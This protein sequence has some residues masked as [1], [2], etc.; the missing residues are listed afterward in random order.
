MAAEAGKAP[1]PGLLG[2]TG[3]GRSGRGEVPNAQRSGSVFGG[4]GGILLCSGWPCPHFTDNAD[5][6]ENLCCHLQSEFGNPK[7]HFCTISQRSAHTPGWG[8]R[9][10]N[11]QPL[12]GE[13]QGRSHVSLSFCQERR[14]KTAFFFWGKFPSGKIVQNLSSKPL[15]HHVDFHSKSPMVSTIKC[16]ACRITYF[17]N[18][19]TQK[20]THFLMKKRKYSIEARDKVDQA[21]PTK[22][23]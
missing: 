12:K 11:G 15:L 10:V 3:R 2:K 18:K 16:K 6:L 4:G 7:H 17:Q 9:K 22:T 1:S 8:T 20:K 21:S 14:E 23:W 19:T 5:P 13:G